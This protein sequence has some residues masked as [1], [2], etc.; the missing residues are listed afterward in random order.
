MGPDPIFT[1]FTT[2]RPQEVVKMGGAPSGTGRCQ[3]TDR[4]KSHIAN[5]L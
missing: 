3:S 5:W 2:P 4:R 1:T